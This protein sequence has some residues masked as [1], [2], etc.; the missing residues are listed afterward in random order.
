MASGGDVP[1]WRRAPVLFASVATLGIAVLAGFFRA[2]L[3]APLRVPLD[4]NEGWNAYHAAAA[5]AGNP[6]PPANSFLI[7]NYPPLSF[8]VVGLLGSS[9]GD[10][11]LAGRCVSLAAVV[12]ICLFIAIAMRR[13]T[14]S[15]C[16]AI[17]AA[18]LFAT[19]LLLTSDYVGM[20]DPQLLGHAFQLAGLL[21]VIRKP[22][23][24]AAA[25][26]AALLFVAGGLVKH[27][28]FALP[29]A[30]LVWLYVFHRRGALSFAA[31]LLVCSIA[32]LIATNAVL[33]V[34]L[35]HQLNSAREFSFAQMK[36]S[37]LQ[38][39]PAAAVPLCAL[40]W[41]LL[42][43]ARDEAAVLVSL[44]AAL[45]IATGALS[46][47]GA[48]VDVNAMF[49]SD[50]ALALATGLTISRLLAGQWQ[51]AAQVFSVSCVIP[52]AVIA[53]RATDWRDKSFWLQ[54][55]RD[56]TALA[57][58]DIAFLHGRGGPAMC[59]NQTFCFWAGKSATVDV[60]NL[61][62]QFQTGARSAGPFLRLIRFRVFGSVELDEVT[63]FPF[64]KAVETV[65]L[66]NYRID[67]QD[68]EGIF[69]VPR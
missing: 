66:Q 31:G 67:H 35:L 14:A 68:D 26:S 24:T 56:E 59:E 1:G 43:C 4:P 40:L 54:P 58:E 13:M 23:A 2:V 55:M 7:N 10:H 46:L 47:G 53:L 36:T 61:D 37:A 8:Y 25:I 17:F 18:L 62:Q 63:P 50:I 32:T 5:L 41:L 42:Q 11:V 60:F 19:T 33:H 27:N 28:L 3:V 6:Y 21:F 51:V 57:K 29:L 65:F 34:N 30:T 12:G 52:F 48:G 45:S 44:Y 16:A 38:W 69:F 20:D 22:R 49:D 9:I 15:W 64:P 39:F